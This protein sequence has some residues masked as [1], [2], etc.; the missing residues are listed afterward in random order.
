MYVACLLQLLAS[1]P[2]TRMSIMQTVQHPSGPSLPRTLP[3]STISRPILALAVALTL[4]SACTSDDDPVTPERE[5]VFSGGTMPVGSGGAS[6]SVWAAPALRSPSTLADEE[7]AREALGIMGSAVVGAEGSC[8]TCHSLGRPTL[9]RWSQQ[10]REFTSACLTDPTLADQA[11]VDEM[12]DCFRGRAGSSASSFVAASFGV[13]S[14]AAHLPWFSFVFERADGLGDRDAEYASFISRVGMPRSGRPLSQSEFDVVAEWF[15]RGLPDLFELVP[16]DSGAACTPGLDP[17]LTAHVEA[18]RTEGWQAKNSEVPLLMFGCEAG[19]SGA[20]CLTEFP[21][22]EDEGAD[23]DLLPG[24]RIVVLHDNSDRLSTYWS[25]SSPDGRFIGSG[26]LNAPSSGF[27]GQILD[28]EREVVIPANFSYDATFFPDNS[29]FLVQQGGGSGSAA[30]GSAS[31]GSPDAGDVALICDQG[32]LL[33][34][35]DE[36]TGEERECVSSSGEIALYQ[37]LGKSLDGDDYWVVHGSYIGDDGGFD[38]VL[39]NPSAAFESDS[40]VTLTPMRNTGGRFEPGSPIRVPTPLSGDPML[41]PS[42]RLLVTRLKG[43]ETTTRDDGFDL[44]S[45][46]QSGYALHRLSLEEGAG[47]GS[48]S[49]E[50]VG[51]VCLSGGKAVVSYDERWMVLHHY[52][53]REDARELGFSSEDDPAFTEYLERGAANLYLVDLLD[54]TSRRITDMPPGE[55][56]LF[57]HFRSDGWIYFVVRTVDAA[58]YFAASDAALVLAGSTD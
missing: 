42:G 39:S 22:A 56:A 35:P 47:G 55:Y 2:F 53:T 11:S 44:V 13:Y 10:T 32:V 27:A 33:D 50:D 14:A 12:L 18:M 15:T 25:R 45:A 30:P 58:E 38:P 48:A 1:R 16:E 6:G 40:V 8:R 5:E 20:S 17:R 31:D 37:Q 9:T 29:G 7:L 49:L 57:P 41:S 19:Q 3:R 54:G 51:R 26:R 52:V 21:S 24:A 36:L 23:W 34:D 4:F 43:E 46:D 28:L